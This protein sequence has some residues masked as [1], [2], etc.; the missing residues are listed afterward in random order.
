MTAA[1]VGL[2]KERLVP[3]EIEN[4]LN[5]LTHESESAPSAWHED[6]AVLTCSV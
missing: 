3:V 2:H 6:L 4:Q 1:S 5:R